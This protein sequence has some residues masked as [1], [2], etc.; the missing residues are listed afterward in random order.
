MTVGGELVMKNTSRALRRH[1]HERMVQKAMRLSYLRFDYE[2]HYSNYDD[3]RRRARFV[4]NN[5]AQCSC[6]GCCN[7]RSSSWSKGYDKLTFNERRNIDSFNDQMSEVDLLGYMEY[8][9]YLW[10]DEKK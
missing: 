2:M 5:M 10:E 4:S 7:L 1:H 9:P 6:P 8:N 3:L